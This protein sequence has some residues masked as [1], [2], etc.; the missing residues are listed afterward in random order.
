M[1]AIDFITALGRMLQDGA[2]R[3]AFATDPLALA[4]R[5]GLRECDQSV[6][7]QLVPTDLEFQARVLLRKRFDL[8]RQSLPRTCE[9]LGNATWLEFQRYARMRWPAGEDHV[10]QDAFAFCQHLLQTRPA[11]LCPLE[12][13]RVQ[14]VHG[15]RRLIVR[16]VKTMPGVQAF[17]RLP[18]GRWHEWLVWFG[19]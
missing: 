4:R 8:V 6:F 18:S 2:L 14:F 16:W 19:A 10:T 3:D 5:L 11:S 1:A 7:L 17:L 12:W 9:E 13:N 15:Q